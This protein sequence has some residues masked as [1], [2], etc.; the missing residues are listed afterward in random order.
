MTVR[1][2]I[3]RILDNHQP[4]TFTQFL[5][6]YM[7]AFYRDFSARQLHNM[8]IIINRNLKYKIDKL[9][10]LRYVARE[11]ATYL[12]SYLNGDMW[13]TE[14]A[15]KENVQPQIDNAQDIIDACDGK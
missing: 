14:E 6:C 2:K 15:A 12:K 4:E 10:E 9:E 13:L 11:R 1:E 3:L 7:D 8:S 5:D